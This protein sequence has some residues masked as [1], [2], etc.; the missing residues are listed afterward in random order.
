VEF[1]IYFGELTQEGAVA[2]F[3]IFDA[4]RNVIGR[5]IDVTK[6]LADA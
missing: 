5:V 4:H 6:Y 1:T 3:T 2:S